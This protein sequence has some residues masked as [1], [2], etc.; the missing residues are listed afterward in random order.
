[1]MEFVQVQITFPTMETAKNVAKSIVEQ[2]LAACVQ[3]VG[4]IRSTY[5][6]N[7]KIENGEEILFLAKTRQVLFDELA[8]VVRRQHPYVC[9]QIIALPIVDANIDYINWMNDQLKNPS[10]KPKT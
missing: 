10:D 1:M 5:I 6:W 4:K 9:P 2:R 3:I 8:D 7:D